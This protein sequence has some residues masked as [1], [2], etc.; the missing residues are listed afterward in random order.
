MVA[1]YSIYVFKTLSIDNWALAF[2]QQSLRHTCDVALAILHSKLPEL[3]LG[4]TD[5]S[6]L[7][8]EKKSVLKQDCYRLHWHTNISCYAAL[9][10]SQ[11]QRTRV[12]RS[13]MR[14]LRPGNGCCCFFCILH[15]AK[16]V[17]GFFFCISRRMSVVIT[18]K[19]HKKCKTEFDRCQLFHK[20]LL[21]T[22][23]PYPVN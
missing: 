13:L 11:Q 1:W 17:R 12:H 9:V 4:A 8:A 16:D 18:G 15:F 14:V 3:G 22:G 6:M 7:Y 19:I 23:A 5:Q 2:F 10:S 21:A 20:K